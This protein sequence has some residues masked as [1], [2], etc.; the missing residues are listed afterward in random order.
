MINLIPIYTLRFFILLFLQ[1]IFF[2][3]IHLHPL[4]SIYIYPLFILLLPFGTPRWLL[5]LLS[6]AMGLSVDFFSG[7]LGM[8]GA[9]AVLLGYLRPSLISIITP[10]GTEFEISPNIFLQGLSWFLLY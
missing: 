7:S 6:A 8:H 3:R 2:N 1:V 4:I 10:K 9:A 5:M